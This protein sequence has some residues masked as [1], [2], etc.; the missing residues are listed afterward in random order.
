MAL[1]AP[2]VIA[3]I[4]AFDMGGFTSYRE[5]SS[6]LKDLTASMVRLF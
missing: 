4:L 6:A 1:I 3:V 2:L 5:E